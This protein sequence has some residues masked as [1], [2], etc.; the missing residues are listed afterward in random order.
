MNVLNT[1]KLRAAPLFYVYYSRACQGNRHFI[2]K[3]ASKTCQGNPFY[4]LAGVKLH[5]LFSAA[6]KVAEEVDCLLSPEITRYTCC[7][8]LFPQMRNYY[9]HVNGSI[10]IVQKIDFEIRLDLGCTVQ[11]PK[12]REKWFWTIRLCVCL[13]VFITSRTTVKRADCD[14]PFGTMVRLGTGWSNGLPRVFPRSRVSP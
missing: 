8:F 10:G 7:P 6:A 2:L 14:P 5:P 11:P 13:S 12:R 1:S 9:F 4:N 3:M